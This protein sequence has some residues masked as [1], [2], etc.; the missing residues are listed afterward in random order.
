MLFFFFKQKTA[1]EMRISDWSSDV[2][3]SDLPQAL[4]LDAVRGEVPGRIGVLLGRLQQRLGGNA[5]DIQAGA[6][7]GAAALHAGRLHAELRGADRRNIAPRAAA[8]H[9]QVVLLVAHL[10]RCPSQ[11]P[12]QG[13]FA[14]LAAGQ[15]DGQG[16]RAQPRSDAHTSDLQSLM[17]TSYAV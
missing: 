2:C 13:K 16:R 17:R 6:A 7:E 9:H 4:H 3:S 11:G 10:A 5:A 12:A 15:P 14:H 1:Y 8:D